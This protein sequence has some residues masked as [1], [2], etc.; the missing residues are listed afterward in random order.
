MVELTTTLP[1]VVEMSTTSRVGSVPWP[2][3]AA[4]DPTC[5]GSPTPSRTPGAASSPAP[6][7]CSSASTRT[8][9][10]RASPTTTTACSSRLSEAEDDRLR[11]AEL[12]DHSVESRSRLSHHIGRLEARGL[13]TPGVV[14]RRPARLLRRADRR[15]TGRSSS[16]SPRTTSP[17]CARYFLD[18][19]SPDELATIGAVFA[20]IDAAFGPGGGC[21]GE[22]P[23][24]RG[25]EPVTAPLTVAARRP[26]CGPGP[27]AVACRGHGSRSDA[28]DD[29][30][31]PVRHAG[32]AHPGPGPP[33][34]ALRPRVPHAGCSASWPS[35]SSQSF[36]GAGPAAGDQGDHRRRHP[37]QGRRPWSPCSPA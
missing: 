20:R 8:S 36:L 11:M 16:E 9:R 33:R 2:R 35:W 4:P 1:N 7:G 22:L 30:G 28:P 13:V 32:H 34:L 24:H 19:V 25:P 17:A 6:A 12:A 26:E 3:T 37:E 29:D 23:R 15:G 18:Q 21:L 14:P 27:A 31:G 10:P 5:A